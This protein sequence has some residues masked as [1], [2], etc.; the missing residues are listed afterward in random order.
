MKIILFIILGLVVL[1]LLI[2]IIAACCYR[3]FG[4][5]CVDLSKEEYYKICEEYDK[6]MAQVY[7]ERKKED[8]ECL[9]CKTCKYNEYYEE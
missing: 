8:D 2:I 4:D 9:K 6:E 7:L 1:Y 5:W 3:D